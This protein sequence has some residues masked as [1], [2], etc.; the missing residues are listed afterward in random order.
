[1]VYVGRRSRGSPM[2]QARFKLCTEGRQSGKAEDPCR[3]SPMQQ[4]PASMIQ[5]MHRGNQG[6][7]EIHRQWKAASMI[8]AVHRGN[9]GRLEFKRLAAA[10]KCSVGAANRGSCT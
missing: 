7:Q 6:R 1:M 8:Q 4:L 9:Q 10:Q 3:G 2:Q 5:A